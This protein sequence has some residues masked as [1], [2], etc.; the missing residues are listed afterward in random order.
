MAKRERQAPP[1]TCARKVFL[2]DLSPEMQ[3][4]P[5]GYNLGNKKLQEAAERWGIG[6]GNHQTRRMQNGTT[7]TEI[8]HTPQAMMAT[9]RM[10]CGHPFGEGSGM[11]GR[12]AVGGLGHDRRW[13]DNASEA[14]SLPPRL[15]G[16]VHMVSPC[17]RVPF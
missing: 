7:V 12:F 8:D 15:V 6:T 4:W 14:R 13:A 1:T 17:P 3:F 5:P 11:S 16:S 10:P 2:C 9:K